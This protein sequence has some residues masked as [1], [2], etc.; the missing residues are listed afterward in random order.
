MMS[1]AAIY[2]TNVTADAQVYH[3]AMQNYSDTKRNH[4]RTVAVNHAQREHVITAMRKMIS[5][6]CC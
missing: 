2:D 3:I 6:N 4:G 5:I 1:K